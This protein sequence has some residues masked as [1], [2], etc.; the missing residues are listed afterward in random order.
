MYLTQRD[1]EF[2]A[3]IF[4]PSGHDKVFKT[5]KEAED[6]AETLRKRYQEKLHKAKTPQEKSAAQEFYDDY[7][8][9]TNDLQHIRRSYHVVDVKG[10]AEPSYERLAKF[11]MRFTAPSGAIYT[12]NN[13]SDFKKFKD[14]DFWNKELEARASSKEF[15]VSRENLMKA[16]DADY[17]YLMGEREKL[18]SKGW[19][20][21]GHNP[22]WY[23]ENNPLNNLVN[24]QMA[25]LKERERREKE[26]RGESKPWSFFNSQKS[27]E[28]QTPPAATAAQTQPVEGGVLQARSQRKERKAKVKEPVK[29]DED[30]LSATLL[31]KIDT[32]DTLTDE[33]K[34]TFKIIAEDSQ[35]F[36]FEKFLEDE[37]KLV[38]EDD[39][40]TPEQ[41]AGFHKTIEDYLKYK[42]DVTKSLQE[43]QTQ[44]KVEYET[45]HEEDEEGLYNTE[46][47]V[48][49]DPETLT[50]LGIQAES[51]RLARRPFKPNPY[52]TEEPI[53]QMEQESLDTFNRLSNEA[54]LPRERGEQQETIQKL[55]KDYIDPTVMDQRA[56]TLKDMLISKVRERAQ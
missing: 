38:E 11:P 26:L 7:L 49:V 51:K 41:I 16:A 36:G 34:R 32:D 13:F 4:L 6:F 48:D 1:Y 20:N 22:G 27:T 3:R 21:K 44:G 5:F 56:E 9:L 8:K 2:P 17:R 10:G 55:L 28:N 29:V 37:K 40:L 12:L 30:L 23:L 24:Q 46:Q 39:S 53:S 45:P 43:E 15:P 54:N 33:Q 35:K 25:D 19:Q 47:N 52:A 31:S 18:L 50:R 14:K 42:D